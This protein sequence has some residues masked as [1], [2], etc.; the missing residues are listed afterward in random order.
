MNTSFKQSAGKLLIAVV[1]KHRC[2]AAVKAKT[3]EGT[4]LGIDHD[5]YQARISGELDQILTLEKDFAKKCKALL[6]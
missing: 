4:C 2:D 6:K 5:L 1:E 3:H